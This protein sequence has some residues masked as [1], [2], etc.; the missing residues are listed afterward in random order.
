MSFNPTHPN[1]FPS[2]SILRS[3]LFLPNF[4][5]SFSPSIEFFFLIISSLKFLT[6]YF[7]HNPFFP[8]LLPLS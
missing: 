8:V 7:D 3:S 5:H 1:S 6:M 4:A 2:D